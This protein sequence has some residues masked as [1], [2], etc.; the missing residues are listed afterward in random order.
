MVDELVGPGEEEVR[1]V[2][3]V[4]VDRRAGPAFV[5]LEP[6]AVAGGL[7]RAQDADRMDAAVALEVGD[8]S[9]GEVHALYYI[10]DMSAPSTR[11]RPGDGRRRGLRSRA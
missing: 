8:L 9:L 1:L 5:C 4:A 2:P 3:Q 7:G 10:C 11:R 6:A